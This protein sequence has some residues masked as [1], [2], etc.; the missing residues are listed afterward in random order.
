MK[1]SNLI[2]EKVTKL[3]DETIASL[4]L[5]AKEE[6]IVRAMNMG[7]LSEGIRIMATI[8]SEIASGK[9]DANDFKEMMSASLDGEIEALNKAMDNFDGKGGK[10]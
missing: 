8:V 2:Q 1:L 9:V 3:Q 10:N 4:K 6:V 5:T 7:Y